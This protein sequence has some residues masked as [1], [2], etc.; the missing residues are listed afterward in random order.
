[1]DL[2]AALLVG[3]FC[4]GAQKYT[5]GSKWTLSFIF[6]FLFRST[7]IFPYATNMAEI[8]NPS[9]DNATFTELF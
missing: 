1:M 4:T 8:K 6:A 3:Q 2:P 9:T 5:V 7:F